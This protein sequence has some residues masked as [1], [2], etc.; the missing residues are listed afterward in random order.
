MAYTFHYVTTPTGSLSGASMA[1]QTE[2]AIN[3]VANTAE[4][5][6]VTVLEAED[7]IEAALNS[8]KN[9]QSQAETGLIEIRQATQNLSHLNIPSG[10]GHVGEFLGTDGTQLQWQGGMRFLGR[11]ATL[12]D[13]P[14]T[15]YTHGTLVSGNIGDSALETLQSITDGGFNITVGGTLYEI[16]GMDFSAITSLSA[17]PAIINAKISDWGNCTYSETQSTRTLTDTLYAWVTPDATAR[18]YAKDRVLSST[19]ILYNNDGTPYTGTQFSVASDGESYVVMY[20]A[21]AC[22]YTN[23]A[24]ITITTQEPITV[25]TLTFTTNA[26]GERATISTGGSPT[27]S[28]VSSVASTLQLSSGVATNGQKVENKTGDFFYVSAIDSL[29]YWD[30]DS[31][32][33]FSYG[34]DYNRTQGLT[35]S[36]QTQARTN[37]GALGESQLIT[38]LKELITQYGGTIP[39]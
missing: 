27:A 4:V 7:T 38:A 39:T 19:S 34:V 8:A 21:V 15:Y 16:S 31:W 5:A 29:K 17:V 20:G 3:S 25:R 35:E 33:S 22:I 6:R 36:Q 1:Q 11:V 32:E 30:G 9:A 14:S 13:L 37:I 12:S 18:I 26:T 28:E 24:S 2:D 23:S 10:D